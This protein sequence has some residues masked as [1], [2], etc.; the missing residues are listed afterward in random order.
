MI[1]PLDVFSI[2]RDETGW[3]G[4]AETFE[5]AMALIHVTGAGSYFVFS[6]HTGHKNFFDVSF[7]GVISCA[8]HR[9]LKLSA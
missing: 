5:K 6:Q 4:S 1:P 9:T 2:N 7:D 3:L 8:D